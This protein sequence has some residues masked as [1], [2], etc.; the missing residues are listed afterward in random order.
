MSDMAD[1]TYPFELPPLRYAYDALEPYIDAETMHYHHDKHFLTYIE[2]LNKA[3]EN[4]PML[5][6][7][8][9]RRLL[10]SPHLIPFSERET[11]MHNAGGVYNHDLFFLG[12]NPPGE[13]RHEAEGSLLDALMTTF[14]SVENF[15]A[16]FSKQAAGVF[17]SGYAALVANRRGELSVITLANQDTAIARRLCPVMLLDVWEHAYYLK[18]KNLRADYIEQAWNVLTFLDTD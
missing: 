8:T 14:G 18:Y 13:G 10:E 2:N 16:E 17:G 6:R 11:V 5:Q 12:L 9:L 1:K 7:L 15:R 3:L 4:F